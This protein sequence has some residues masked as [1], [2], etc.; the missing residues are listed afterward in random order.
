MMVS[1]ISNW[2][3]LSNTAWPGNM[4]H[5]VENYN[6]QQT[7]IKDRL[8]WSSHGCYTLI[9]N[10]ISNSEENYGKV[11]G[12]EGREMEKRRERRLTE[13]V[14]VCVGGWVDG[15]YVGEREKNMFS[16]LCRDNPQFLSIQV[17]SALTH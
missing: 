8:Y 5:M 1:A 9:L 14:S 2:R 6:V 3:R 12:G 11:G 4:P 15:R 13:D 17:P 10:P 16:L 7:V